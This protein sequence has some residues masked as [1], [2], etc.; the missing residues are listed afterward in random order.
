MAPLGM[1]YSMTVKN[2]QGP[3]FQVVILTSKRWKNANI[4]IAFRYE[5]RYL[6]LNGATA[7]TVRHNLDLHILGH[8]F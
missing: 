4:S 8:E 1:F 2:F 5:V 6:L 3:T 7:N